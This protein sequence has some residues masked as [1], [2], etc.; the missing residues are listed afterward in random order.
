LGGRGGF[1][2]VLMA[3][4]LEQEKEVREISIIEVVDQTWSR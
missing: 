4:L 1:E 3:E 2:A